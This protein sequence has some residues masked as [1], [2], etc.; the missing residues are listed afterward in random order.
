MYKKTVNFFRGSTLLRVSGVFPERF[1]NLC[2]QNGV[3]FWD[4]SWL[5]EHTLTLRVN[6]ASRR[7]AA[8]LGERT[9]CQVAEEDARGAPALFSRLKRRYAFWAGLAASV[10]A[11]AV[12]SQ[13]IMTVEVV[14]NERV[15][16]AEILAAAY[17]E[18]VRPGAFGPAIDTWQAGY[19]VRLHLPEISWLAVNLNGTRAQIVV[20]EA[21][22]KPE[23]VDETEYGDIVARCDG[24]ILDVD[25]TGGQAVRQAGETVMA[26]EVLIRGDIELAVPLYSGREPEHMPVRASGRVEARTWRT[27]SAQ[28]PLTA[29]VKNYTGEEESRFFLIFLGRRLDFFGKSGISYERYD[30][31]TQTKNLS[32]PEGGLPPLT[33]G[34][35]TVREYT[36]GQCPVRPEAAEELLRRRLDGA[37]LEAVGEGQVVSR[38]YSAETEDGVLTVI[39]RAECREE[40]GRFVP[41]P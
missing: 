34:R 11:V 35:E 40:I 41:W 21:L 1:L 32:L 37:L 5:D 3:L 38:D 26:G 27:L 8:A 31:I 16:T 18:G 7:R 29:A 13:F 10:L 25:A 20:R 33:L 22:P 17:R 30:K 15:P 12:L 28:I 14:G 4:V 9:M 36:L 24:L 2:A 6:R 39:L 23:I 19:T